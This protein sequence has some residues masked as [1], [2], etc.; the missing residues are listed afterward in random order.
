MRKIGSCKEY[1][2]TVQ[3]RFLPEHA[4]GIDATFVYELEGAGGG[5]WTVRVKDKTVTV[6]PGTVPSPTV[7]YKM[8][9]DDYV[10]LANGDLNGAKAFL[11]RKLKVS[12]SI[13][14]AQKMNKFLPPAS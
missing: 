13:P 7:T 1:F 8:K 6:E 9:A 10:N 4:S 12:G 2:E 11:T 3:E 14:M 5:T